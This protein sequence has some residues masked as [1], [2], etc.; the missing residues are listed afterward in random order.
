ML[1][2]D[3][4]QVITDAADTL[5]SLTPPRC[6]PDALVAKLHNIAARQA[7][8]TLA[9]ALQDPRFKR[10]E[11]V[12]LYREQWPPAE[13]RTEPVLG[14]WFQV[15]AVNDDGITYVERRRWLTAQLLTPR[16]GA[17]WHSGPVVESV[18]CLALA[19]EIVPADQADQRPGVA[20]GGT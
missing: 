7:P 8:L 9:A 15:R 17:R 11:V 16:W 6:A 12:L 2:D 5:E 18:D 10:R 14:D 19:C 1:T 13:G 3:D 20:G 4:R